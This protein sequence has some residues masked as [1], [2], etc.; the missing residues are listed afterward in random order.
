MNKVSRSWSIETKGTLE[1][2][3]SAL[4]LARHAGVPPH[5]LIRVQGN[6]DAKDVLLAR[7]TEK[8]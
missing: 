1:D 8:A 6:Y 4:Q 3:Q 5:A 2:I 7:W